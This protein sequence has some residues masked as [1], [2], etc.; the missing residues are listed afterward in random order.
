[1]QQAL[2]D[3]ALLEEYV[4]SDPEELARFVRLGLTSLQEALAPL[5]QALSDSDL[6]TVKACGHRAKSTAR[7]LGADA[8]GQACE[9]LEHM[10]RAG[11]R[12]Q[13]IALGHLVL[14]D[15]AAVQAALQQA[16][17]GGFRSGR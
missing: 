14:Q 8:F 9:T 11:E 6:A 1:M 17:D 3:L 12:A 13:S 7:H 2:V 10:A 5:P 4:G 15:F 16:I